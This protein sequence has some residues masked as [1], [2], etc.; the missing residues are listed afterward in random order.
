MTGPQIATAPIREASATQTAG[1]ARA[2]LAGDYPCGKGRVLQRVLASR[3]R[4]VRPRLDEVTDALPVG[5]AGEFDAGEQQGED[6]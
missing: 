2:G 6:G 3:G 4:V 5:G 1:L